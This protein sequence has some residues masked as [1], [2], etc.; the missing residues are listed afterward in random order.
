MKRRRLSRAKPTYRT[1]GKDRLK[2]EAQKLLK[3]VRNN[4]ARGEELV[5]Q[6]K[7]KL[8]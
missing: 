4:I 2:Q 1:D 5:E 8:R 7:A 6:A 3:K